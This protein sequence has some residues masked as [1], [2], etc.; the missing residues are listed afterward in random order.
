MR[1][2]RNSA[3]GYCT[4]WRNYSCH[5]HNKKQENKSDNNW[6]MNSTISF[7]GWKLHGTTLSTKIRAGYSGYVPGMVNQYI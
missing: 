5:I 6:C 2:Y 7:L 3:T 1:A 4:E